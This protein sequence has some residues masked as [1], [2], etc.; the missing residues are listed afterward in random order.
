MRLFAIIA[1][2]LLPVSLLAAQAVPEDAPLACSP[3]RKRNTLSRR[4]WPE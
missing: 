1:T 2:S 3:G 4:A